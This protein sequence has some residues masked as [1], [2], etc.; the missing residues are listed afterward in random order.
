M[1]LLEESLA[2]DFLSQKI[3]PGDTAVVDVSKDGKVKLLVGE[4]FDTPEPE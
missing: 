1:R 4:R 3:Q 2:E